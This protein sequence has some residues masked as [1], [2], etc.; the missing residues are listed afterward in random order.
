MAGKGD[1]RFA[2]GGNDAG[3]KLTGQKFAAALEHGDVQPH[4]RHA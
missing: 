4:P 3:R 1:L 2:F